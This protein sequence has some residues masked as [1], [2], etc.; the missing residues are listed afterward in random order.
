[1]VEI[2]LAYL[3]QLYAESQ[4]ELRL[5]KDELARLRK[6]MLEIKSPKGKE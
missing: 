4:I 5:C 6:E 1:M 2:T 3:L